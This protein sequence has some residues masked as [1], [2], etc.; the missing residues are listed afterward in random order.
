MSESFQMLRHLGFAPS[1]PN[2]SNPSSLTLDFGEFELTAREGLNRRYVPA[3][4]ILGLYSTPR[5]IS[6]INCELQPSGH[7]QEQ[8]AAM[9]AYSIK[10][11]AGP[12][13][14][15]SA[16]IP[17]FEKAKQSS[18]LLPWN[19]DIARYDNRPQCYIKRHWLKLALKELQENIA[20][21]RPGDILISFDGEKLSFKLFGKLIVMPAEGTAWLKDYRIPI[22]KLSKLPKRLEGASV[23]VSVRESQ[24]EIHRFLYSGL[25]EVEK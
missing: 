10:Q 1:D 13:Y 22:E 9:L 20:E 4:V 8:I 5:A 19:L 25:I 15:P 24:L 14:R 17:W 2:D 23:V 18:F 7:T 16:D 3:V 6:E 21:N 11:A 12:L